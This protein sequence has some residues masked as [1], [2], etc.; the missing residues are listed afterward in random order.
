M[1]L[2]AIR[3]RAEAATPGPW[4]SGDGSVDRFFAGKNT[5]ATPARVIVERATY[6]DEFD[7][8]TYSDIEFIAASRTDIPDMLAEI[9]RLT[10]ALADMTAERDAL[11]NVLSQLNG[12]MCGVRDERD[13]LREQI[14]RE[15]H[16]F[17]A[18]ITQREQERDA[19]QRRAE[20]A[21]KDIKD[22]ISMSPYAICGLFCKN[23]KP[24][25]G[26]KNCRPEWRG[27]DAGGEATP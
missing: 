21:E 12:V 25:C 8:Q 9:D 2:D 27:P 7:Q 23:H 26:G 13:K 24:G 5:V 18:L 3:A 20:A 6:N 17:E 19:A 16:E 1:N 14:N 4:Y 11:T 10:A 22:A 15:E